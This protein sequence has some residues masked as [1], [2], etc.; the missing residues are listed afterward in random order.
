MISATCYVNT[1]Q[2]QNSLNWFKARL[3]AQKELEIH[4]RIISMKIIAA[5]SVAAKA[6]Q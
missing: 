3:F 1:D 6:E 4:K 2:Y 5:V